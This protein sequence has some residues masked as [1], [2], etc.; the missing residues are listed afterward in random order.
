MDFGCGVGDHCV[1]SRL[2]TVENSSRQSQTVQERSKNHQIPPSEA[3]PSHFSI[4]SSY[5]VEFALQIHSLS[6]VCYRILSLLQF[7]SGFWVFFKE[8]LEVADQKVGQLR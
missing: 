5:L 3:F 1:S 7:A 6:S 2:Q 4:F 8:G